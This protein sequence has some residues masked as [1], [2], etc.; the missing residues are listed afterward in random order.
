MRTRYGTSPWIDS[1]PESRRPAHPRLRGEE[2]ADVVIVGGGLT[3]CATALALATAGARPLLVEADRLGRAG[4]GRHPG[5]LLPDPG[6]AFRDIQQ[7][8]GLRAAR[9]VFETWRRAALDAAALL[10]RAR[11]RCDVAPCDSLIVSP[12]SGER[13]L[14]REHDARQAAGLDATW[15]FERHVRQY[16][17]L[18]AGAGMRL[19]GAFTLDPYRACLGLASVA[20]R[21][22]ARVFE[23]SPVTAVVAGAKGVEI[24]LAGGRIRAA[25]VVVTTGAPTDAFKPLR[26]HFTR[27]ESYAALTEPVSAVVRRELLSAAVTLQDWASPPHRLRWTADHRLL[28]TGADQAETPARQRDAVLVQRTGHLMYETLRRYPVISGLRPEYG[29]ELAYGDT[30][31]GLMHVGAHRNYPHHLFALGGDG[32]SVTGSFL[33]ARILARAVQREPQKGDEVFGWTR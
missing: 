33:A 15:L 19:R 30:A 31:D 13:A 1:L 22:G 11:I 20:V 12:P 2:A 14:R 10:R 23:R 18:D 16:A 21:R 9:T 32:G 7:M 29:W 28:M 6:P 24:A 25:T 5:L 17:R 26:R 4:A 8:H 27:R 3:G